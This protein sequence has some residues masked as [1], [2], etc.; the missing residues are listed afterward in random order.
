LKILCVS[1]HID[2]LVYSPNIKKRFSHVEAIVGAGDL[3]LS[4]YD[5]IATNLNKPLLFVF[6]NHHLRGLSLYR[7]P[8]ALTQGPEGLSGYNPRLGGGGIYLDRRSVRISGCI[9]AGLGGSMWYNGELNQYSEIGML[10]KMLALV[11]R[12]LWNR[13]RFGRF[14]D[15][16]VTHS[17]PFGVGDKSDPCHTGFRGFLLFMRLFKPRFLLHGHI[18]LY[19]FNHVRERTYHGTRVINV[20]DHYVLSTEDF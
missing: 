20:Y 18:H 8:S 12:L 1:D 17:A 3:P 15:I 19:D 5:F 11:P 9:F 6:G 7:H 16:L 13:I 4:Y 14:V 10:F 2:P